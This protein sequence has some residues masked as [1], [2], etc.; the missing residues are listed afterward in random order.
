MHESTRAGLA[1]EQAGDLA[2][3]ER[4]FREADAD[5]DADAGAHLGA[6]LFERG[7]VA[8]ARECLRRSDQRGSALGAFRL[9]FLLA[10]QR[11]YAAAEEAYRRAVE[12]GNEW[13]AG[14]LA[15]L[16]RYRE[17]RDASD[18]AALVRAG[19]TY[20]EA[21]D[22]ARA[23]QAYAAAIDAGHPDHTANA[24]FNLGTLHQHNGS[25]GA[26]VRAY[27]TAMALRHPEFSPKA[28]VNLGFV[29]F[30]ALDDGPGARAAFEAAVASG[31]PVQAPLAARNLAA[32]DRVLAGHDDLEPVDDD[33]NVAVGR[34][35]GGFK[36]RRW[37]PR[38]R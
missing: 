31:H 6:L 38:G 14:N 15:T 8:G 36:I 28:A 18:P 5:G 10:N 30:N 32:M 7:D 33:V 13:A 1:R 24:W 4:L 2:A 19:V 27:R 37:R 23:E 9:G 26:A 20:A 35:P 11:D 16:G 29:L 34:G 12:R 3:A 21:G 22:T 17:R 25:V